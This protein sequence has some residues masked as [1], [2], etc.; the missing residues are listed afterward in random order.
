MRTKSFAD[1]AS[2][3]T[4]TTSPSA[5]AP[6]VAAAPTMMDR[7]AAAVA[8]GRSSFRVSGLDHATV[9]TELAG[10]GWHAWSPEFGG[11]ILVTRIPTADQAAEAERRNLD[12]AV[13]A[14]A[15]QPRDEALASV[16]ED[17]RLRRHEY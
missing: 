3:A 15:A 16:I 17:A 1:L 5:G 10:S 6:P 8:A 14:R 7:V 2:M 4:A 11:S 13:A 12:A 9:V